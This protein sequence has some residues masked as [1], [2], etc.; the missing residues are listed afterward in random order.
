MAD[1]VQLEEKGTVLYPKTH[2][3]AV[4]DLSAFLNSNTKIATV[5]FTQSEEVDNKHGVVNI[6]LKLTKENVSG[7]YKFDG[8]NII[9]IN[10]TG[11]YEINGRLSIID[12]TAG[13]WTTM[14]LAIENNGSLVNPLTESRNTPNGES[15][16]S[17]I[18][19]LKAGA[20]LRIIK[21]GSSSNGTVLKSSVMLKKI[22]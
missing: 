22:N 17:G 12:C 3:S 5:Y 20:T 11:L 9:E 10:E 14:S 1:I 13:T 16:I 21:N 15:G 4:E 18:F 19:E 8:T 7:F 6:P 2:V